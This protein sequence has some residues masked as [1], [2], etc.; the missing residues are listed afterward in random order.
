MGK[1]T[2]TTNRREAYVPMPM[3]WAMVEPWAVRHVKYLL[4]IISLHH[5]TSFNSRPLLGSLMPRVTVSQRR[6]P[7]NFG[8]TLPLHRY[9]CFRVWSSGDYRACL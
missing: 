7:A 8:N 1:L 2:D 3:V 9:F 5:P 6:L 4:V